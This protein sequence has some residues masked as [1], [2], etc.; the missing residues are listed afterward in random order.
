MRGSGKQRPQAGAELFGECSSG[1]RLECRHLVVEELRNGFHARFQTDVYVSAKS[2]GRIGLGTR[3]G[4]VHEDD[5]CTLRPCSAGNSPSDAAQ[6][7]EL[8]DHQSTIDEPRQCVDAFGLAEHR[9]A[10]TLARL[11]AESL[12][13]AQGVGATD[14]VSRHAT[15][16]LELEE[17]ARSARAEDAVNATGIKAQST[18]FALQRGDVVAAH[19]GRGEFE[20]AVSQSPTRFDQCG[21][22]C[23]VANSTGSQATSFLKARHRSLGRRAI[24][25]DLRRSS[26]KTD[27]GQS[28][29][30]I[31]HG[32]A[33]QTR[34]QW[35]GVK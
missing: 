3:F 11:F 5:V 19:V 35:E 1:R 31:T 6:T 17:C 21:P 14:A 13:I 25:T 18:Q 16:A 2:I 26:G 23:V 4:F 34:R 9:Y 20:Q 32:L 8:S 10:R 30:Q 15:T 28:A 29:L 27:V 33:A 22:C 24:R 12:E 7:T